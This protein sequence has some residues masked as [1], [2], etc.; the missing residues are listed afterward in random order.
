[1]VNKLKEDITGK[2]A[3]LNT[4]DYEEYG[5]ANAELVFVAGSGFYPVDDND[6]FKLLFIV[7]QIGEDGMPSPK[8]TTIMRS[9]LELLPDDESATLLK[10]MEA[11]IAQEREIT[12]T[13]A[14]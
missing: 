4:S 12:P 9:S 3:R 6:N 2:F 11:K 7:S 1:M 8:G 5:I 13:E 10:E 14:N